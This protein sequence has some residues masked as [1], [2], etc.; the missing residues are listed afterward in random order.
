[1]KTELDN[2]QKVVS[3][4]NAYP[5]V[6]QKRIDQ[7]HSTHSCKFFTS[8]SW[9]ARVNTFVFD[10]KGRFYWTLLKQPNLFRVFCR[11]YSKDNWK[12]VNWIRN[13]GEFDRNI[14]EIFREFAGDFQ[15]FRREKLF[16]AAVLDL[17][18]APLTKIR[19][20]LCVDV[21][22]HVYQY[23][24][25]QNHIEQ[26]CF[27]NLKQTRRNRLGMKVGKWSLSWNMYD[28]V[29]FSRILA[30]NLHKTLKTLQKSSEDLDNVF[31]EFSMVSNPI[32]I[33]PVVFWVKPA[34]NPKKIWP[35]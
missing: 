19:Y 20:F 17:R 22:S 11:F 4:L 10:E 23:N 24:H 5:P 16:M 27:N 35:F 6:R 32:D 29:K 7:N 14:V 3:D 30:E 28:C 26:L 9:D 25:N 21:C 33:L 34:K 12:N 8:F 2:G 18:V 13:H 1:L 31:I 15:R